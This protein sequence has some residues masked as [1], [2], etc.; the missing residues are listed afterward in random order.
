MML[1]LVSAIVRGFEIFFPRVLC[2]LVCRDFLIVQNM[3]GMRCLFVLFLIF[4]SLCTFVCRNYHIDIVQNRINYIRRE[5][6][7]RRRARMAKIQS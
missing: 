3:N 1:L 2:D 6:S 7:K 4:V 5:L